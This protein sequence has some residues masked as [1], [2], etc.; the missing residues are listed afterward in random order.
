MLNL[1]FIKMTIMVGA[2]RSEDDSVPFGTQK[3]WDEGAAEDMNTIAD[4]ILHQRL[5]YAGLNETYIHN[6]PYH[7]VKRD[8]KRNGIFASAHT[9]TSWVPLPNLLQSFEVT[10]LSK[11]PKH[12]FN[13]RLE[14]FRLVAG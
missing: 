6:R 10:R 12:Q 8:R 13:S 11:H 5:P 4:E 2:M 3:P 9:K 7:I 14:H 1:L